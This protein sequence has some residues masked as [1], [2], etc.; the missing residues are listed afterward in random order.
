M[1]KKIAFITG[2]SGQDGSYLAEFLLKKK[3]IVHGLVRPN[4]FLERT[5]LDEIY[6]KKEIRDKKLVLHYGD[7]VDGA[8]LSSL[9]NTL[10]PT[11]IYNLGAQSHVGISFSNPEYSTKVNSLGVISILEAVKNLKINCKFYQAST[12]E[13]FGNIQKKGSFNENSGF[14]PKSPYSAAKLYSYNMTKLY[15]EA[16]G[17][18]ACNGILFNHESPRRTKNFLTRKVTNHVAN[19]LKGNKSI[20]K[21]GN[22]Y[23]KRDW[24]YAPDFIEGIYKI[25][26]FSRPDDYILATNKAYSVKEFI[27]ISYNTI[28]IKIRWKGK[29]L[30]EKGFNAKTNELL[31]E[32]DKN[33]FR[34]MDVNYLKGDYSKA[35][36][37]LGWKPK[38][39]LK[40][41][42]EE[43]I[44]YDFNN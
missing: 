34:P 13:L 26:Q 16:Y 42:I 17:I 44:N 27:N 22:L 6:N 19:L 3:Y 43:M 21:I 24:G 32:V 39:Q 35:K 40:Q 1:V 14:D 41:I 38:T 36:K 9:I 20:L 18:F 33:Y 7:L 10:R 37:I 12:S 28:G 23:S 11:E 5:R 25:M 4:S 29:N 30:N 31:V 15:R 2:I 8:R